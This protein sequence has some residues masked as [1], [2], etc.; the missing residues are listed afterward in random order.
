MKNIIYIPAA[1]GID[2]QLPYGIK[3]WEHY[4]KKHNIE[5]II[6]K[7]L[8]P[9]NNDVFKNVNFQQFFA[10]V[11]KD[12]RYDRVL[13][14]DCDTIVRWDAPNVFEKF[15]NDTFSV[16]RDISGKPSGEYHLK[17]WRGFH[18]NIKTPPENYFNSGFIL[19]SKKNYLLLREKI[20]PYYKQYV[21]VK[22]DKSYR[23]DTS[24]QTPCN[25]IAYD[26]LQDEIKFLNDIWNN[27]V[28]FKYDD[29]SFIQDS[30]I[31]HFTGPKLGGWNKKDILMEKIWNSIKHKYK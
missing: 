27:M 4:C 15:P 8:P 2:K 23:I 5:L 9:E 1:N 21:K 13:I 19:L 20:K 7:E 17:Q 12:K 24:D 11:L 6:S 29:A 31:W 25:I 22:R 30:Y 10:P 16:V 14:V 26:Y 3:S 18:N 28:M